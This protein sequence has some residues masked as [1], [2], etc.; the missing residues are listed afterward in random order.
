MPSGVTLGEFLRVH[1]E[2]LGTAAD[3]AHPGICPLL[4][5][6][7]FTTERL[8]VQ[9]H[10]NDEYAQAHHA[11]LGKTE[12]W[13]V[14]DSQP[15]GEVAIGFRETLIPGQLRPAA[16]SG[17]IERLLN[18]QKVAAGD[19]IFVP[20]GTVHAIGAGLIV[21]E[22]QENSDITYRLYD[23]GRP[24]ELHLDHGIEVSRLERH[25]FEAKPVTLAPWRDELIACEYF[26]IERLRLPGS[27]T[28]GGGLPHYLLLMCVK[29]SGQ[30]A[31]QEAKAGQAWFV[32]AQAAEFSL[33][34][35]EAEWVLTYKADAPLSGVRD[36]SAQKRN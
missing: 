1:P 2:V 23:Y 4:V 18:W 22:V 6:F 30:I 31:G 11:C 28:M 16:E 27:V 34:G 36:D 24:R 19:L 7:L 32:P 8:S 33:S 29:G 13:Y 10:P 20:A 3:S 21:C 25:S 35:A 12:A 15:P 17:E 5:K 9:V 26:R 14:L